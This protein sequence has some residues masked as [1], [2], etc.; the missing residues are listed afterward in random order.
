[1]K[2]SFETKSANKNWA[3]EKW[4]AEW[5][6]LLEQ[7]L[8]TNKKVAELTHDVRSRDGE[9]SLFKILLQPPTAQSDL[10]LVAQQLYILYWE[11]V[12]AFYLTLQSTLQFMVEVTSL[13]REVCGAIEQFPQIIT[14]KVPEANF[15]LDK[16]YMVSDEDLANT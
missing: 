15:F 2:S 9:I 14:K 13:G 5:K 1:M 8:A 7:L 6:N 11:K 3:E 12:K 10:L 16:L 4:L